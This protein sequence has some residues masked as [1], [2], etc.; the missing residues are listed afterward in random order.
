MHVKFKHEYQYT[1]ITYCNKTQSVELDVNPE[2]WYTCIYIIF[3]EIDGLY[4][5]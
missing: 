2:L 3:N 5:V 4:E 1:C